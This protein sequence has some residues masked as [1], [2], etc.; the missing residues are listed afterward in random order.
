MQKGAIGVYQKVQTFE[1][2]DMLRILIG[3]PMSSVDCIV[4]YALIKRK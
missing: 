1:G 2:S 4:P 3:K